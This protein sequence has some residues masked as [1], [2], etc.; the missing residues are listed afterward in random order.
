MI[1]ILILLWLTNCILNV[2]IVR[3]LYK[4]RWTSLKPNALDLLMIVVPFWQQIFLIMGSLFCLATYN[5][6]I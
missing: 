4:N 5:E 1:F 2:L 3:Y 6:K